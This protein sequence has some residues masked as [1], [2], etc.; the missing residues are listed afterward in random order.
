MKKP[1]NQIRIKNNFKN[2]K[3]IN[4]DLLIDTKLSDRARSIIFFM[5]GQSENFNINIYGLASL[6][7]T[8]QATIKRGLNELEKSGYLKR[9]RFNGEDTKSGQFTTIY[10]ID[11]APKKADEDGLNN[12]MDAPTK[13]E[14][15][16]NLALKYEESLKSILNIDKIKE[17]KELSDEITELIRLAKINIWKD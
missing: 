15:K 9:Y 2:Y 1:V 5:L 14:L 3:I 6:L 13:E 16:R 10:E 17:N 11:Q 12:W 7:K 8:S 4:Q